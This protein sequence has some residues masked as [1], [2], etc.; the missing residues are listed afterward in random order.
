MPFRSSP[1][2]W[3][4]SCR[5]RLGLPHVHGRRAKLKTELLAAVRK[6][7]GDDVVINVFFTDFVMQ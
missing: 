1:M 3:A 4:R 2:P 7:L 6:I 5:P